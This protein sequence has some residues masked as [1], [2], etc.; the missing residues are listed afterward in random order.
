MS[1]KQIMKSAAIINTVPDL[2]NAQAVKGA[3]QGP[4][5]NMC[6][7]SILQQHPDCTTFLDRDSASLL[8]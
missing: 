7:A 5:S 8:K 3:L 6:P 2:R 1:P 4:V